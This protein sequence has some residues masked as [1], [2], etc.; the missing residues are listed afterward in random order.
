MKQAAE[1]TGDFST[2]KLMMSK[3]NTRNKLKHLEKI[4]RMKS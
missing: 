2:G 3:I 4:L 1:P